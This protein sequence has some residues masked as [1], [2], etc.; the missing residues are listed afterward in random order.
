[1]TLAELKKKIAHELKVLPSQV[2]EPDRENFGDFAFPC[3][4]LAAEKRKKPNEIA[5]ELVGKIKIRGI[6]E[7]K[8]VGPYVNF[9]VDWKNIGEDVL[10]SVNGKYGGN[11]E[12]G[13]ALVEHTS[14]N[15]NASPHVG[16]ARNAIIGDSIVRIL[17]FAGYKT[18]THYYVNDIGKQIALLVWVAK[19]KKL[20]FKDLLEKYVSANKSMEKSKTIEKQVLNL[21]AKFEKGD[22]AVMKRFK[23]IV[24]TCI[25][26]QKEILKDLGINYDFFD[27]ESKFLETKKVE[28]ILQRLQ[29]TGKVE[30][31]EHG[32]KIMRYNDTVF[33]L[34]RSDGTTLYLL[35]DIAY[36][37]EKA[38]RAKDGLNVVILGEDQKLYFEQL[39]YVLNLLKIPQP[40]VVHYS[41]VLLP[42]GGKMSTRKGEVVLL[43]DFIKEA[44][45]KAL[46]EV[47]KRYPDMKA[48]QQ[49]QIAKSVAIAA[50]RYSIIK[51]GPEKNVIFS[52]DEALKFEGDTGPYLQYT[53]A[54]ANSILQKAG[55]IKT[56]ND[57]SLLKDEREIKLLKLLARYPV[58][59]EK[60]ARDLRPHI[61]AS[62]LRELA[63][64][65]N[66]FYQSVP[67]IKADDKKI[68]S[69]RLKLVECVK[70]VMASGLN[71]LGIDA[72]VQM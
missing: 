29:A 5:N 7:I 38:E 58:I 63:D 24:D 44:K 12:E 8:A 56:S 57:A 21:L 19:G 54:R 4:N 30:T 48:K 40:K 33:V 50:V 26:G 55:T 32:R 10:K 1:M 13:N 25:A 46:A 65:F 39:S 69:V 6:R 15:P 27:Y 17:K 52:F 72:P 51:V 2:E 64:A 60:T 34:T 66:E 18:E 62:Y 3:F 20:E 68:A 14:I 53:H 9:F 61:L 47:K 42:S 11:F 67:V 49:E 31:D 45:E 41:F 22:K 70:I 23:E 28:E 37:I 43:E 71:L 59:V 16:R 36:A 35:R